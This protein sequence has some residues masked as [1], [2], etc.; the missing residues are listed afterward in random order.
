MS[1]WKTGADL[2]AQPDYRG[3]KLYPDIYY[4]PYCGNE[5]YW[6]TDYGQ[7]LF[8]FCPYCGEPMKDGEDDA[9]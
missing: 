8:D 5:A 7:Q 6:D 1:K 2:M 3:E 9:V 4:C